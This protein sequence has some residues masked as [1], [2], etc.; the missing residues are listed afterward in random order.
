MSNEL[1]SLERD[2][3]QRII[4]LYPLKSAQAAVDRI[5]L[6]RGENGL[7]ISLIIADFDPKVAG[8]RRREGFNKNEFRIQLIGQ[9]GLA[10]EDSLLRK[11]SLAESFAAEFDLDP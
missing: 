8:I 10:A 7:A 3:A 5:N 9:L 11:L 6:L 2:A 4:G 1:E